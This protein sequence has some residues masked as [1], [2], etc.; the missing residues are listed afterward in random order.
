MPSYL[1]EYEGSASDREDKFVR[2][3]NSFLANSY[4]NKELIIVSDACKITDRIVHDKFSREILSGK[5]RYFKTWM[6]QKKFSGKVRSKGIQKANGEVI[7]YL[8]TD[9]MYG[10]KHIESVVSQM[11]SLDLDWCYFNDYLNTPEGLMTK[12]VDLFHG[13]IGTSSIAHRNKKTLDW[14][15]CNGYGH[16]W[17]FIEKLIKSS[18]NYEKV[19]GASYIIC[20]IPN[21]IDR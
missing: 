5:I 17:T 4:K 18:N 19:Y 2:A 9:D 14:K 13:S 8:D 20:H 11:E 16:D 10:E 3:V 6:K 7:L 21:R 1:G 12:N 15:G